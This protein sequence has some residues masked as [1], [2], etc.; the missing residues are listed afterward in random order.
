MLSPSG[1]SSAG[2]RGSQGFTF[3]NNNRD[4][5][6]IH[7]RKISRVVKRIRMCFPE[8]ILR[9]LKRKAAAE[10]TTIAGIVRSAVPEFP[11]KDSEKNRP[12]YP[13][14]KTVGAGS[15]EEGALSV[16]HDKYLYGE[17]RNF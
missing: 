1:Y 9:G 4:V 11:G 6:S 15:S 8:D 12:E 3:D 16:N 10:K 5:C 2:G 13:L 7:Y 14:W 17:K